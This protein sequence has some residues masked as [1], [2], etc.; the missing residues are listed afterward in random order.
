[1]LVQGIQPALK[2]G[3]GSGRRRTGRRNPGRRRGIS[4]GVEVCRAAG[5]TVPYIGLPGPRSEACDP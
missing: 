3:A 2:R 5:S 1:M 4:S